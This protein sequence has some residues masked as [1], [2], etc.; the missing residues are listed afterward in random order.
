V[1]LLVIKIHQSFHS[2][3][4]EKHRRQ[5]QT[6]WDSRS[7]SHRFFKRVEK[8]PP[9]WEKTYKTKK[10]FQKVWA[11]F[12]RGEV[13]KVPPLAATLLNP[14]AQSL[15]ETSREVSLRK[16]QA[17]YFMEFKRVF[18]LSFCSTCCSGK[19]YI[20]TKFQLTFFISLLY[21][22]SLQKTFRHPRRG[23]RSDHFLVAI[24]KTSCLLLWAKRKSQGN[25]DG[26]PQGQ[27]LSQLNPEVSCYFFKISQS[28]GFPHTKYL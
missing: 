18:A 23:Q 6:I 8:G 14:A 4:N 12:L 25:P 1:P 3:T 20:T 11:R 17:Y 10:S 28:S 5:D 15:S 16:W 7:S 26:R 19:G 9:F 2:T 21:F 13:C 24:K 27:E 22:G